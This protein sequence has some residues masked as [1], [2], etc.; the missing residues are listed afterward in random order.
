MARG[1][2]NTQMTEDTTQL[3]CQWP[4]H[5]VLWLVWLNSTVLRLT[6]CPVVRILVRRQ[7]AWRSRSKS[8]SGHKIRHSSSVQLAM[9]TR[10]LLV[11]TAVNRCDKTLFS[12]YW[13]VVLVVFDSLFQLICLTV[14]ST[15]KSIEISLTVISRRSANKN[16]HSAINF[17]FF[18]DYFGKSNEPA[19]SSRNFK[20]EVW[21]S[22]I[23]HHDRYPL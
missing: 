8:V 23:G 12:W 22:D 6:P 16:S 3:K 4:C 11:C 19:L 21:F 10:W 1:R 2:R 9:D 5:T 17:E 20:C 18:A 7:L 15:V 13:G 14:K